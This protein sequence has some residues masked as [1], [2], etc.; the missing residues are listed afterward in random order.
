MITGLR[1]VAL[2]SRHFSNTTFLDRRRFISAL[3]VCDCT[4]ITM[5][6]NNC[7]P[8]NEASY[9]KFTNFLTAESRVSPTEMAWIKLD[10]RAGRLLRLEDM[11][12]GEDRVER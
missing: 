2:H 6:A 5:I 7:P 8:L 3:S 11:E 4:N 10:D 9:S 1:L 12:G